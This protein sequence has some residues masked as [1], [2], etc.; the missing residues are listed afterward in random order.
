MPALL[1]IVMGEINIAVFAFETLFTLLL[2]PSNYGQTAASPTALFLEFLICKKS[3]VKPVS[4]NF[5]ESLVQ[6]A[7]Q[8]IL[9]TI[10]E[11]YAYI[12]STQ[13]DQVYSL[14]FITFMKLRENNQKSELA[15]FYLS[16]HFKHSINLAQCLV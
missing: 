3:L 10:L 14:N 2:S 16:L 1:T 15:F 4:L 6:H 11:Y 7:L 9:P 8:P 5:L 13:Y 12:Y